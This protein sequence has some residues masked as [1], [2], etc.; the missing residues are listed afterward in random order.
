MNTIDLDNQL[1]ALIVAGKNNEAFLKFYAEDVVAQENDEE[2]HQGRAEW[3]TAREAM[4]ENI[5]KLKA[6]LLAN[7]ASGDVSFSEWSIDVE[8]KGMGA[9]TMTQVAVR[10]WKDGRVIRERFYHK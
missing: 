3:M 7:A 2:E 4:A 10:R 9:M 1:N 5:V 6:K 8:L